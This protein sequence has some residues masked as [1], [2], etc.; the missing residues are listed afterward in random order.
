MSI[1]H[2]QCVLVAPKDTEILPDSDE[3]MVGDTI[4]C[5]TRANP[6]IQNYIWERNNVEE[7]IS[8]DTITVPAVWANELVALRCTVVNSVGSDTVMAAYTVISAG[9]SP[10]PRAVVHRIF[11]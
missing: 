4:T 6:S 9:K 10:Q 8:S 7:T 2:F 11:L 1:Y 3:I 5:I